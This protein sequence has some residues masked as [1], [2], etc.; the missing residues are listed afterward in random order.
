MG[1][2]GVF[3]QKLITNIIIYG[4]AV[5]VVSIIAY[6]FITAKGVIPLNRIYEKNQ[7]INIIL[8]QTHD[9][10]NITYRRAVEGKNY[11][12]LLYTFASLKNDYDSYNINAN[13]VITNSG[14]LSRFDKS[15]FMIFP[16]VTIAKDKYGNLIRSGFTILKNSLFFFNKTMMR[17]ENNINI[18]SEGGK[19]ICANLYLNTFK[20]YMQNHKILSYGKVV[21]SKKSLYARNVFIGA[22]AGYMRYNGTAKTLKLL[23][24][25]KKQSIGK[26]KGL[27]MSSHDSKIKGNVCYF[28]QYG[29]NI[30]IYILNGFY[31]AYN[32]LNIETLHP[33]FLSINQQY[34]EVLFYLD[35]VIRGRNIII[36]GYNMKVKRMDG[37]TIIS[38]SVPLRIEL[39]KGILF[40]RKIILYAEKGKYKLAGN[41][42]GILYGAGKDI[43]L[44]GENLNI[45]ETTK[46]LKLYSHNPV[47]FKTKGYIIK[48]KRVSYNKLMKKFVFLSDGFSVYLNVLTS[49]KIKIFSEKLIINRNN[50]IFL[51][52]K[53]NVK[54]LESSNFE[55]FAGT[56]VAL[57]SSRKIS[58]L[59]SIYTK[60]TGSVPISYFST[61]QY[62]NLSTNR[63]T[64]F[65]RDNTFFYNNTKFFADSLNIKGG[66]ISICN[67]YGI[68]I[69][70]LYNT[71][72][73]TKCMRYY[74]NEERLVLPK[75]EIQS[76]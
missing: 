55:S 66:Y 48:A 12:K 29:E 72:I 17:K 14:S 73:H 8:P 32:N 3:L 39:E 61:R 63:I 9:R 44:S 10:I 65:A 46:T 50:A 2:S 21:Y 43:E 27:N 45:K 67:R 23:L 76:K 54:F 57:I 31:F 7:Q 15:P 71:K 42:N 34:T 52:N 75:S 6:T 25:N 20:L 35:N 22:H 19:K 38:S 33:V 64:G 4:F 36:V 49:P 70:Y 1:K 56:G 24:T 47:I 69:I 16:L 37:K 40:A 53:F 51:A 68:T 59:G 5:F 11:M 62:I 30:D 74:L 26:L 60:L 28:Q 18:F 41:I 58:M 13:L